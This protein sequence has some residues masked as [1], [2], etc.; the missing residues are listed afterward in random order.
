MKA[1]FVSEAIEFQKGIDPRESMRIGKAGEIDKIVNDPDEVEDLMVDISQALGSAMEIYLPEEKKKQMARMWLENAEGLKNWEFKTL[2]QHIE[3]EPEDEEFEKIN[4]EAKALQRKGWKILHIEDNYDVAEAV[5]YRLGKVQE[6]VNFER[7]R[8]P[9]G[10]MGIGIRDELVN[11][12]KGVLEHEWPDI[13]EEEIFK[14]KGSYIELDLW[15]LSTRGMNSLDRTVKKILKKP[16]FKGRLF[17]VNDDN[18]EKFGMEEVYDEE[19]IYIKV[20]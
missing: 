14:D 20:L 5:L 6:N 15:S 1:R 9:K 19:A 12:F 11:G 7:G 16:P 13:L 2:L 18:Y 17:Y 10:A 4:F 8:D 3:D